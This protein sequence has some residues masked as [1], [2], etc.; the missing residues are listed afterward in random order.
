MKPLIRILALA[1]L[2]AAVWM[3]EAEAASTSSASI[4][5]AIRLGD[6][7]QVRALLK[8]SSQVHARD[9]W[10]NTPLITA[11]A[12]GDVSMLE[13]LVRA[14]ADVRA[15][16]NA[17]ADALLR[18]A[19][20][21]DEVRWL[22]SHG[23]NLKTRTP[24]G[25]TVLM[26]A[27][28]KAGN[29]RT[30]KFLL[31]QGVNPNEANTYG[32]TALM[33]AVASED[34]E[35]V[36]LLL[37]HG[38]DINAKPHMNEP[39]FIW[40][41]GR[42]PLMWAAFQGNEAL[43][44]L[45]IQ[46]GA[47]VNDFAVVGTALTQA[48]WRGKA[49]AAKILLDAGA[50]VNHAD[51]IAHYTPLHWAASSE[52]SA[53]TL[54]SLLLARG[55]NPNAE[56]GQPVDNFLGST[57]TPL[58]LARKR[59]DTPIVRELLKAGAK[60]SST[61]ESTHESKTLKSRT[62]REAKS[63]VEAIQRALPLLGH[64]A[65]FSAVQFV[66]HASNQ[67]CVSCHQQQVPFAAMSIA[68][69][70]HFAVDPA[71]LRHQ[72]E[73]LQQGFEGDLE[74]GFEAT[75]HPEPCINQGYLSL[76]L[77][78][79]HQPGSEAT[80][81]MAHLVSTIQHPDGHW[82]WNL[83]RPPIQASEITS[84]AFGIHI[85]KHF[86][87]PARQ[88]EMDAQIRRARAWLAKA[89]VETTEEKAYQ[90]LGLAWAGDS[91]SA[92]RSRVD[93]FLR[94]QRADG[95]W[96]QLEG[97][98]SDAYGTGLSLYALLDAGKLSANHPAV[99][100]GIAYLLRTQLSDGSWYV[101]TRAHPFQPPMDSGFPHGKDSWISAS[102][103]GW[104]VMALATSLD[105]SQTPPAAMS[106]LATVDSR[107]NGNPASAPS[108]PS[109]E[110]VEFARDIQPVL[111]RS[112]LTC[113]SGERPKGGFLAT[114]RASVVHGGAR[115]EPGIVPGNPS[116]SLLM[117]VV[118]DQVEDLEMPPIGKRTRFPAL[119]KEEI[120]KLN[121]WISQG[122]VWPETISLKPSAP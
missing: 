43:I 30:V 15:T 107:S 87:I 58:T 113:H 18:A 40:G 28:R 66:K 92:L 67:K 3:P 19:T 79:A 108:N 35:C 110:K 97:L 76:D 59:G 6:R 106:S 80:D 33:S 74:T 24:L 55:A 69:S 93:D 116:E 94:S 112:C 36:K 83:P 48:A 75:F 13:I 53:P 64:T 1:S 39:G 84:T 99:Q 5:Q 31:E 7:A 32:A 100:R 52:R 91:A 70:R 120:Q 65:E 8:D 98:Q 9:Q 81:S 37:D 104:A 29:S 45:L 73:L 44:Q 103:T 90:L 22:V 102:A 16:N 41:G 12:C 88:R 117:K 62:V 85:L 114:A 86:G 50:E 72:L 78:L 21:E 11:A 46:R 82:D 105:P 95:G 2:A 96:A 60:D 14:G 54:V 111:E 25:N 71:I 4:F 42:T 57:R 109:S 38:A 20:F 101:Q 89:D 27:A 49:G 63:P 23:A 47:K 17:G 26:L 119:S 61:A 56:G 34:V 122:A 68:G 77:A 118:Q 121:A 115:G 51:L 10:G